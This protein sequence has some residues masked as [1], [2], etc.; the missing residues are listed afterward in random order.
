MITHFE[1]GNNTSFEDPYHHRIV[2]LDMKEKNKQGLEFV[3][4]HVYY[5]DLTNKSITF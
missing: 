2:N 4:K 3:C 1:A 5:A